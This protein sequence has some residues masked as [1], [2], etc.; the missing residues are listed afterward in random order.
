ML[1]LA[2][3]VFFW[4]HRKHAAET[5]G[6]RSII[7]ADKGEISYHVN[8]YR[9]SIAEARQAR[10]SLETYK[11]AHPEEVASIA[12]QFDVRQGQLESFVKASFAANNK[13]VSVVHHY[14]HPDSTTVDPTDSIQENSFDISDG[15]LSLHGS[16]RL[17]P[18]VPWLDVKWDYGYQDTIMFAVIKKRKNFLSKETYWLDAKLSNPKAGITSLRSYQLEEVKDKRWSIG[19]AVVFDPFTMTFRPGIGLQYALIK[20]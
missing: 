16:T 15:N 2:I 14:F 8:A 7:E 6:L 3:G 11:A 10:S 1:L 17:K 5:D 4:L 19:P 12:K 9:Q 13:G 18:G 20:F